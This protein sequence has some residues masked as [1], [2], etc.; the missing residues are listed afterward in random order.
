MARSSNC[1][2]LQKIHQKLT[3]L[4]HAR[5]LLLQCLLPARLVIA[6]RIG[7]VQ[8]RYEPDNTQEAG[9]QMLKR[10]LL[11]TTGGLVVFAGAQAADMPVKAKPVQYVKI[12]SLYGD[13]F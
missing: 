1:G 5:K 4:Q 7:E 11:G 10:L 8:F 2:L 6:S 9:E 3:L 12:C 13:G